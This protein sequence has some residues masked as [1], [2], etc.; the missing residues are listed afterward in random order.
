MAAVCVYPEFISAA[1]EGA[2]KT[3]ESLRVATVVNFPSGDEDPESVKAATQS[4]LEGG[5]DEIDL[6]ICYKDYL[7]S[8][9]STKSCELIR[10]LKNLMEEKPGF[11]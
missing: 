7:A 2:G 1:K 5:A 8:G 6:V 11:A 10:S 3:R 9:Q 4:A